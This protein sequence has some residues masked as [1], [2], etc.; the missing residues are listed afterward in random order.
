[1]FKKTT[2]SLLFFALLVTACSSAAMPEP[3]SVAPM[4][5]ME[6][7]AAYER[8]TYDT[9]AGSAPQQYDTS[10]VDVYSQPAG[11]GENANP[12]GERIVI[13]NAS[14]SIA[15]Q[16]P[17]ENLDTITTL[18]D[19]FGGFVISSNLYKT[20]LA[21]GVEVPQASITIRVPAERL[22]EALA[23]IKSGAG[24]ILSENVSGQDVTREYTDLQSRL[25]NLEEA[26]AQ[27]QLIMDE[28]FRTEDVINVFNQLTY[29]REQIEI[30]KGQ[31]QY[32]EQSAAFSAI[33][34]D[35]LADAAIQPLTIGGWEPS[36]VAREAIQ[37]LIN[38]LQGIADA[39]IWL[40]LYLLPVGLVLFLPL[41]L[42]WLG[43]KRWRKS[44]RAKIVETPMAS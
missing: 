10:T 8:E 12:A 6:E 27:L 23:R 38:T 16:N 34:V 15:V 26:E 29:Y 19:E 41:W 3:M 13:K 43:I 5:V 36:G 11:N 28:A 37:A 9:G 7:S 20:T 21:S 40:V 42:V 31:I 18:A 14:L 30:V 35:I 25:K 17:I 32:Y 39:A 22:E 33:T 24:E 2:L 44:R 4:E 1:M